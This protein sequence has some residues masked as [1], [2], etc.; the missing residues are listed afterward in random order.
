[1]ANFLH[2]CIVAAIAADTTLCSGWTAV[3]QK[4]VQPSTEKVKHTRICYD[5]KDID[6]ARTYAGKTPIHTR[7]CP[8]CENQP[9][10]GGQGDDCVTFGKVRTRRVLMKRIITEE[11]TKPKAEIIRVG[12]PCSPGTN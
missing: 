10:H 8:D 3:V 7:E 1:M 6:Y 2:V 4:L 5:Y 9:P 11:V 12:K